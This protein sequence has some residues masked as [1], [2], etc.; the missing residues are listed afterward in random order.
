MNMSQLIEDLEEA[1]SVQDKNKLDYLRK[2]EKAGKLKPDQKGE[3]R[4][5]DRVAKSDSNKSAA[6]SWLPGGGAAKGGGVSK[7]A[8]KSW[9]VAEG[10][11]HKQLAGHYA[12]RDA[13]K[14]SKPKTMLGKLTSKLKGLFGRGA[15]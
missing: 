4:K 7:D 11:K 12:A 8:A 13:G 6:A 9:G 2:R 14:A 3:L 1:M 15:G 10:P 5:L